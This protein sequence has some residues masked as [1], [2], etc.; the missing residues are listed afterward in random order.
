MEK[1]EVLHSD[2]YKFVFL[3]VL[4]HFIFAYQHF[5]HYIQK[6]RNP[7]DNQSSGFSLCSM[8][9]SVSFTNMSVMLWNPFLSAC[10]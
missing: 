3:P 7:Q 1:S 5:T 4:R 8:S 9:A 6:K 2:L 10:F